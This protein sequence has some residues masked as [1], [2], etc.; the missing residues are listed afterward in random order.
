MTAEV[1][2]MN[3]FGIALAADS[4][5]TIG[6]DAR[7]I[8]ASAEKLFLL[9]EEAPVG[10]MIYGGATLL[11]LPWEAIIKAHRRVLD[12]A[13]FETLEEYIDHFLSFLGSNSVMFPVSA[14]QEFVKSFSAGFYGYIRSALEKKLEAALRDRNT[15]SEQD[16]EG[17]LAALVEEELIST[18]DFALFDPLPEDFPKNIEKE[19]GEMI[20]AVRK[21]VLGSLP[22]TTKTDKQLVELIGEVISRQRFGGND[23]GVVVAGFGEDEYYPHLTEV[24]MRGIV[25]DQVLFAK[26]QQLSIG[27]EDLGACIVPFAQKE[28]V[29]TF[30]EGIDPSLKS[31][32]EDSVGILFAGVTETILEEVK[33]RSPELGSQLEDDLLEAL[34]QL[35]KDLLN[36]WDSKRHSSYTGPVMNVVASLPKDELAAM[37]ES[38]VSITKFKR[39][40][41]EQQETVGGPID[42]VVITKG[43]GFVWIKRKHYFKSDLNPRFMSNYLK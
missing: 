43:D 3:R 22:S 15:L 39:R 12:C 18:K 33:K 26:T 9:V 8:Y 28:M 34:T 29:H 5:V 6:R 38:L 35:L 2:V 16:I 11:G 30:M 23:S 7:K 4:A 31:M 14:Q 17:I 1:G 37:A 40:V 24:H 27:E 21:Q 25:S 10:A 20:G 32:I 19:H 13:V 41:S 36:Q 42:V